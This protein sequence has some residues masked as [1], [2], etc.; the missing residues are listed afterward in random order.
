MEPVVRIDT[1]IRRC[2]MVI[3][4]WRASNISQRSTTRRTMRSK[5][6]RSGHGRTELADGRYQEAINTLNNLINT[7]PDSTYAAAPFPDWTSL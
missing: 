2:F 5:P 6:R 4:I 3:M 1:A 7:Y